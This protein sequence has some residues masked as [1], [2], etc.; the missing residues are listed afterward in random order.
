MKKATSGTAEF[1]LKTREQ[2]KQKIRF[3]YYCV[4]DVCIGDMVTM[5]RSK[6]LTVELVFS[7]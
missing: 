1:H 6:E 2:N 3:I 5:W 7:L 4:F